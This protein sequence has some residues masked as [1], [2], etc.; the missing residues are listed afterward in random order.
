MIQPFAIP[1]PPTRTEIAAFWAEVFELYSAGADIKREQRALRRELVKFLSRHAP[2][3]AES[4]R[5]LR[6][7]FDRKFARWTEKGESSAALLDGREKKRGEKRAPEIPQAD[8]DR[9]VWHAAANSGG[10]VAQA[11]RDFAEHGER[12][13][14]T[15][16]TVEI[17]TRPH[18][19]KSQV[20]HRLAARL[21]GE[22]KNIMPFYLGKKAKDDAVAHVERDYSKLASMEIVNADD[23]TF[24]VYF[25]V[26]DGNGWFNLTRGQCLLM[27]D[28]RS[29]KIIAWSLQP[30]RNY[31]SLV[32]RTLMNSVCTGW[33]IPGTWYFESGI[34]AKLARRQR[35]RAGRLERCAFLA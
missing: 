6:V 1:N 20:N 16:G 11:L 34:L 4:S 15:A 21:S 32:I 14:L 29:W 25:Y 3:L 31:N 8:V 17:I 35:H 7:A 28:V 18:S 9:I 26:P 27:L 23:F 13:G 24:P 2:W 33:G 12:S 5:A 19:R 22:V 10:R 30:E